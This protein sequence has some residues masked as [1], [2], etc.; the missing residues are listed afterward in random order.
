MDAEKFFASVTEIVELPP[1][2]RHERLAALHTEAF[3]EYCEALQQITLERAAQPALPG[4]DERT[5]AQIV[6]HIAEWD[7]FAI[8]SAS[9]ML[10]GSRHPRMITNLSGYVNSDGQPVAF[11]SIDEFNAYQVKYYAHHTWEH[12]RSI[13]LDYATIL[14]VMFLQPALLNAERLE[15][16]LPFRKRLANGVVIEPIAMGW[17]LWITM[18][19]HIV[20]EHA[21]EL[22]GS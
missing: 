5:I 4:R 7:R 20:V 22:Y 8:L 21:E 13:S 14:Y 2:T 19:Q 11:N 17:N 12:I 15:S 6:A 18:L 9:D 10:V 3:H 1:R 16:T